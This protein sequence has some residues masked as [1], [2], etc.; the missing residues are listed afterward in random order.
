MF[1]QI[2]LGFIFA[3]Y[4]LFCFTLPLYALTADQIIKLK[5]A[6]VDD[7]TIQMLIEQEKM[8]QE[9]KEG[10]GVKE[11][12]RPGGGKD[13]IYYSTTT[14]EEETRVQQEERQKLE[15]AWE[16]LRNIIIDE[17]NR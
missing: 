17:R 15:R 16:V 12:P 5:E 7:R 6:G 1:Q 4:G 10:V 2:S 9:G 3:F 14:Q 8:G 13:K 11:I